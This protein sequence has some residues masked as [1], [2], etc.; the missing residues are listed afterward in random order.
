MKSRDLDSFFD[1]ITALVQKCRYTDCAHTHEPGC[2]V[3]KAVK[4]G[5]LD[6]EKYFNYINLK[7]EAAHYALDKVNKKEKDRR[8]GKFIKKAKQGRKN[9]EFRLGDIE[10][11]PIDDNL[12]DVA[13]SNCVVNLAPDKGKVFR[14]VFRVL[15]KGG[16]I[17][18]SDIVLLKELSREQRQD[19]ELIAGCV[20]G[21]MLKDDYIKTV[22][23]AGFSVKILSE[24]KEISKRQYQ[25]IPLESLKI[26]AKKE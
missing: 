19:S 7:K 20:G 6:K 21:A 15:K 24:D 2:E 13:I 5:K 16:R 11:L 26:E 9:V 25:G 10:D 3:I 4:S 8:F 12:I 17:Y 22:E 1:E 18:L 14:E 23:D